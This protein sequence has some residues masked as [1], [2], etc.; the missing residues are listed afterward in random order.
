[1]TNP[2]NNELLIIA[3]RGGLFYRPENTLAAFRFSAEIGVTWVECDVRI[4]SDK[5]LVLIHDD[6]FQLA[7]SRKV[8]V[9]H[10]PFKKLRDH[11]A[12][13]GQAIPSVD[14]LFREF[15]TCMHFDLEI[16]EMEVVTHLVDLVR[17]HNL[18]AK[19]IMTSFMPDAIQLAR[20]IAPEIRRGLLVDRLTGRLAGGKSAVQAA[21]LLE[22]TW[23]L[24]HFHRLSAE[25]SDAARSEGMKVIPWTV[26]QTE[27]I[28]KMIDIGIDG[29]VTD[30]P[31]LVRNVL[32]ER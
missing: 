29:I 21:K 8:T 11:D 24:P 5:V 20:D 31:L 19:V 13:G 7:N 9:H 32:S 10:E 28:H 2:A 27:D 6:R 22:C 15:G 14:E 23:F 17:Q 18:E 4:S 30:N 16:K 12:G 1:M 25:W 3:H 26:N